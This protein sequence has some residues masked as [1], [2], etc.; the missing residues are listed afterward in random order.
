MS[1]DISDGLLLDVRSINLDDLPEDDDSALSL[2]LRR[3]LESNAGSAF[4]GFTSSI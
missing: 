3:V 4:Y 2:A 1:V